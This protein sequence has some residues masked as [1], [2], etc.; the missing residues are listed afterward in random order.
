MI[1]VKY[2]LGGNIAD[3]KAERSVERV[4]RYHQQILSGVICPVHGGPP[5]LKVQG[6]ALE[7]LTVTVESCCSALADVAR[8]RLHVVSRRDQE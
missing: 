1:E 5:W 4:V 8:T 3:E 7:S 6:R 2:E